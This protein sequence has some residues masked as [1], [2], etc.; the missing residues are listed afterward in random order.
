MFPEIAAA[1]EKLEPGAAAAAAAAF[2][3]S[4]WGSR[5]A[6]PPSDAHVAAEEQML[7]AAA[8]ASVALTGDAADGSKSD[9]SSHKD[10]SSQAAE[11]STAAEQGSVRPDP[12]VVRPSVALEGLPRS[13]LHRAL[14]RAGIGRPQLLP[15]LHMAVLVAVAG[16]LVVC[17]AAYVGL[18]QRSPWVAFTGVRCAGRVAHASH[19]DRLL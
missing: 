6:V 4:S 15:A 13:A 1:A 14:E 3:A 9:A 8:S 7:A 17:R 19:A 11:G 16:V 18:G 5:P 2:E 10:D 12:R